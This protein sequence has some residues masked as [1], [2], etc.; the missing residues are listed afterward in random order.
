MTYPASSR[1]DK[2]LWWEHAAVTNHLDACCGTFNREMLMST[3]RFHPVFIMIGFCLLGIFALSTAGCYTYSSL[4]SARLVDEGEVEITPSY[5]SQNY[6]F[7]GNSDRVAHQYGVQ[8]GIGLAENFN[9]RI[10]YERIDWED[11]GGD[12][13][14]NYIAVEPKIGL[15]KDA[16]A[17]SMPVGLWFGEIINEDKSIQI[18]PSL[19]LTKIVSP[20]LELNGS[21]KMLIFTEDFEDIIALNLGLGIGNPD[22]VI[23]RPEIGWLFSPGDEGYYFHWS[24]GFSLYS[25]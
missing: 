12:A 7:G 17:V 11:I 1:L 18:H 6:S 5:S 3:S 8:M 23:I 14:Y 19:H 24:I 25:R 22:Q 21:A 9:G 13:G 15:V 16:V 20:V 10:R 4:Q 2:I